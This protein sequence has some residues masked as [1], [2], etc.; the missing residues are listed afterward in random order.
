MHP[1]TASATLRPPTPPGQ[2]RYW[3]SCDPDQSYLSSAEL[4]RHVTRERAREAA[5]K[6]SA[7]YR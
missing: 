7:A 3:C 1:D 2:T 6:D 4:V 5:R